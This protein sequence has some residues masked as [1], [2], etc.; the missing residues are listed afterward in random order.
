VKDKWLSPESS[1]ECTE[2]RC[3]EP[4]S[5]YNVRASD[6]FPPGPQRARELEALAE[7]GASADFQ[8]SHLP[9]QS[10]WAVVTKAAYIDN[11]PPSAQ[12]LQDRYHESEAELFIKAPGGKIGH[13]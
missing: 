8:V 11:K 2:E 1:R 6:G 7:A 5:Q 10:H 13:S 9:R 3:L 4:A 12:F